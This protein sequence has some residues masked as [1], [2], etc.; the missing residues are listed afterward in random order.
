MQTMEYCLVIE[1][2]ELIGPRKTGR[3]PGACYAGKEVNL[4]RSHTVFSNYVHLKKA[5]QWRE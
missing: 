2:E 4:R 5:R 3:N 1:A